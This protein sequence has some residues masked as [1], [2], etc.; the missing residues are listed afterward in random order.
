MH[1]VTAGTGRGLPRVRASW[2]VAAIA[3]VVALGVVGA[4]VVPRI[5]ELPAANTDYSVAITDG[6]H[7]VTSNGQVAAIA[8]RYLDE[9]DSESHV[10]T[11]VITMTATFARSAPPL[12][13]CVPAGP[14]AA[15]PD[16]IVWVVQASG[17]FMTPHELP[18]SS[19]GVPFPEGDLVIDD[20]TA[21]ILGVYP[22]PPRWQSTEPSD[23]C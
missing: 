7:P 14:V 21:T 1:G 4:A 20:A 17:D 18:W 6:V 8:R 2:I 15:A 16:R 19:A 5:T 11:R 3:V 23:S 10:P 22:R 12:E 13:A 9:Q